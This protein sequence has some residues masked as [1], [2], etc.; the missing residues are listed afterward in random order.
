MEAKYGIITVLNKAYEVCDLVKEIG[1]ECPIPKGN[2]WT[3]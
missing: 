1:K 3:Q 2:I